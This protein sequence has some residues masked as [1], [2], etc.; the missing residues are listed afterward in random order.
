MRNVLLFLALTTLVL[1]CSK[2]G[3]EPAP[4]NS[5]NLYFPPV[6]GTEWQT[7]DMA[8]LGWS[9]GT[10][11]D[12]YTYLEQKNSKAFIVLK[13]GKIVIEKYFGLFT[14]DSLWYWASAG[15]TLTAFLSGI[16]QDEGLID[17]SDKTSRFL[18]NGWTALP[19]AKEDLITIRHQLTMT[20]GL[21]DDVTP[22]N[23]CTDP[24]CLQY[25]ADAG[26][27]WAYHNAPYTLMEKVIENAS[28]VSYNSYFQQK[29]R[30]RVGMNGLWIKTGF[31]NVY[32]SNA[33]S[34]ARFGLLMLNKGKWDQTKILGDT[35]YFQD[36]VS[37]SQNFN[38]SYGYLTWLNGKASHML[39]TLELTFIGSMMPNAPVDMYAALGKN[40]QK[41]Y[42]VPSQKLV[43]IRMGESAG[44]VQLALSSFD[45]ELWGKLKTI[46][47]Y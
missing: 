24:A 35:L 32:Y 23:D 45:N 19:Q 10:V 13:N 15:K 11:N 26:T 30:D 12:L 16:A 9:E 34:M 46:I 25:R 6:S 7:T 5:N 28:G 36:Q 22:N 38:L 21:D 29:V 47:G 8:S 42:V 4:D 33:R 39:P 14:K 31:N 17:L 20:T 44:N 41:I 40:D 2:N 43:V 18:G 27:R 1:S 37:S 3:G